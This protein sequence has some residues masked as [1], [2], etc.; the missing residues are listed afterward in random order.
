ML[1]RSVRIVVQ[2]CTVSIVLGCALSVEPKPCCGVDWYLAHDA[3]RAAKLL[4]CSRSNTESVGQSCSDAMT[5]E[6][7][8]SKPA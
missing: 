8:L 2:L 3:D 1:K 5:A 7:M 4:R 6:K